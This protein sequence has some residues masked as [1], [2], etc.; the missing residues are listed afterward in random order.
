MV[1]LYLIATCHAEY[2]FS[3]CMAYDVAFRRKTARFRLASWS[4]RDPQL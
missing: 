1:Y 3:A 4:Q 2:D